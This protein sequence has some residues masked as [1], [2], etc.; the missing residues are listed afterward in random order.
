MD[1]AMVL[2]L[3]SLVGIVVVAVA[4]VAILGRLKASQASSPE[5]ATRLQAVGQALSQGAIQA[6]T[7]TEKLAHLEPVTRTVAAVQV[8]LRGVTERLSHVEQAQ[9][10]AARGVGDLSSTSASAFGELRSIAA[11]LAEATSAMRD[12]LARAKT[13]LTEIK[14]HERADKDHSALLSESVKRLEMVL[15][16]TNSKGAA[17]ENILDLIFSNLPEDWQVRDFKVGGK[18]VEFGLRLPNNLILPVDSKWPAT[19]LVE[20]Y[21]VCD[22][23]DEQHRLRKEIETCVLAKAREVEKYIDP[24]ITVNMG[25]AVVPDAVYD[26]CPGARVDAFDRG[27]AIIS[28]RMF[29]PYL[30]LVYQTTARSGQTVDMQKLSAFLSTI[31]KVSRDLLEEIDG[32]LS[33]GLTMVENS[34]NEMRVN[35]GKLTTSIMGLRDGTI[36]GTPEPEA[37]P[38][39]T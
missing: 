38:H 21:A 4:L 11:S 13:D 30:L 12:E 23:V 8:E 29:V 34:R 10:S 2:S 19:D 26:L 27:V 5:V 15:A 39:A 16:G 20:R 6:A 22:V 25:V 32:R 24:S 1:G 17:G 37:L 35:A 3:L 36:A 14:A 7:M 18:Q 33:R 31:Q 28:Y 9:A